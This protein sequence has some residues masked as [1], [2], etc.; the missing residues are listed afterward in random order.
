M[1][2]PVTGRRVSTAVLLLRIIVG[3][4]FIIHGYGKITDPLHW[5]DNGP[6]LGV[7][8][9]LQLIVAFAEF[10]G[11]I[12]LIIG[13]LTPLI[14]F[15]IACE[16]ATVIL[17]VKLPH[18]SCF[19]GC[20]GSMELE[21]VYLTIMLALLLMGPGSYSVDKVLFGRFGGRPATQAGE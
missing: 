8:P 12:L 20:R 16:M 14:A 6:L 4:A 19:V 9:W 18:G 2:M 21:A 17:R 11:G 15:L 10:G 7:P 13:L 1:L 5:L 3:I